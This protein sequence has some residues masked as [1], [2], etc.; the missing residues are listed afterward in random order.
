MPTLGVRLRSWGSKR[1]KEKGVGVWGA[2]RREGARLRCNALA[3]TRTRTRERP[4]RNSD[5][6]AKR[7]AKREGAPLTDYKFI[8]NLPRIGYNQEEQLTKRKE[9][10]PGIYAIELDAVF[11]GGSTGSLG[12]STFEL[13][14][15][16][17]SAQEMIDAGYVR[18]SHDFLNGMETKWAEI[19][20]INEGRRSKG[21]D[22]ISADNICP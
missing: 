9:S 2:E 22:E 3:E 4:R 1:E 20:E 8:D 5:A 16:D 6:N 19:W 18:V 10:M 13:F 21:L 17:Q 7:N 14:D 15:E 12:S 11:E